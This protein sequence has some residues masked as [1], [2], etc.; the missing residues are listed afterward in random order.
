L[1]DE[2]APID[3]RTMKVFPYSHALCLKK[4]PAR[5]Y[6]LP[7]QTIRTDR[8]LHVP[9]SALPSTSQTVP[10]PVTTTIFVGYSPGDN[11]VPELVPISKGEAAARL[12]PQALNALAH[13]EDGLRG[14]EHIARNTHCYRLRSADLE[15]TCELLTSTFLQPAG[16]ERHIQHAP[17]SM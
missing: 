14:A 6:M 9:V 4:E 3:L 12:Y 10:V 2:L 7:R 5:A 16:I 17:C 11:G 15:S 8:T 13:P 1:S